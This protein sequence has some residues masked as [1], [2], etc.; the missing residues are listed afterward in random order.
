MPKSTSSYDISNMT[1]LGSNFT[2]NEYDVISCKGKIAY[3]HPGNQRFRALVKSKVAEFNAATTKTAKG[4]FVTYVVNNVRE[5][6][7]AGFV[8]KVNGV[9]YEIGNRNSREKVGQAFRD[10]LHTKYSSSVKAK[11]LRRHQHQI[12]NQSPK[13]LPDFQKSINEPSSPRR[14]SALMLTNIMGDLLQDD[15]FESI[16]DS[17]DEKESIIDDSSSNCDESTICDNSHYDDMEPLDVEEAL[18]IVPFRLSDSIIME[19]KNIPFESAMATLRD[20]LYQQF[21]EEQ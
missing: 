9:W 19:S 21:P 7:N 18:P 13:F 2:P 4:R 16:F 20:A 1:M 15:E 3:N 12:K 6:G 8:K 10:L 11:A 17:I 14:I 5:L